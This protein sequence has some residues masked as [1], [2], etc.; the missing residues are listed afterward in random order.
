[1]ADG[2]PAHVA[3]LAPDWITANRSEFIGRNEWPLN[4]PDDN[5]FDYHVWG[6]M[7]ENK[8]FHPKPRTLM[9]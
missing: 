6:V 2:V 9:D 1:M 4:S 3:K 8:I 5:P 7:L